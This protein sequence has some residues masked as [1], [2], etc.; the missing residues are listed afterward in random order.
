MLSITAARGAPV[1]SSGGTLWCKNR[2]DARDHGR[3]V[4]ADRGHARTDLVPPGLRNV[5]GV[6]ARPHRRDLF[7]HGR[8]HRRRQWRR[9]PAEFPAIWLLDT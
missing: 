7:Y 6:R 5:S 3:V 1:G 2:P 4:R 9:Q 8:A